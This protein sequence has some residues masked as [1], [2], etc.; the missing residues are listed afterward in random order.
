MMLLLAAAVFVG[1]QACRPCHSAI[2]DAYARTPMARS[3]GPVDSVLPAV[4]TAAGHRYR[5]ANNRLS[6]DQGSA[7]FD[8]FVGSNTAGRSY[9][10]RREGYLYELPVTWYAQKKIWDASPGYEREPDVRL[11]RPI[12]PTC[13]SCHASRARPVLGTQNRY[14]DPPFLDNGISCERCHGAGSDHISNPAIARMANPAKLEADRRDSVCIQCHM[15]GGA[16]IE[17]PGRRFVDY[18]AGDKLADFVTY[19]V[20][21]SADQPLKVTS[22]VE[23]LAQSKCKLASGDKLWCGTCHEPHTNANR[24]QQAC[25]GCHATAHHQEE[26]CAGCHMP[27]TAAADVG[28]G[29]LTDHGIL[30]TPNRRPA[31]QARP[32]LIAFLGSSDDRSLGLAYSELQDPRA[33]EYLLRAQPADVEVTLHL[34]AIERD[35]KRAASLYEAV[36]RADPGRPAALVNLGVI[37]ANAG[38]IDQ[39]AKLWER[40]LEGNPALEGA[41]VNLAQ[42]RSPAQAR[43]ILERYLEFDPGSSAVRKLIDAITRSAP[44]KP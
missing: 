14:G 19:F 20:W 29:E 1:S 9:L 3:S 16:R 32:E 36:L 41:A 33:R 13:L 11:N 28:H 38:Q 27:K 37:Y 12:D 15:T 35:P 25:L 30:R 40:A 39:A 7:T 18:R 23:R 43:V 31:P 24:T 4:F 17:R 10:F 5:I 8:F 2:A 42:V 26:S 44:P 34:A 6:F 21:N 22:H